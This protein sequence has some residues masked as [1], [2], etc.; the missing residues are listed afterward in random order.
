MTGPIQQSTSVNESVLSIGVT[1]A[2]VQGPPFSRILDSAMGANASTSTPSGLQ[3][4]IGLLM[5]GDAMRSVSGESASMVRARLTSAKPSL[6]AL[7]AEDL[8]MLADVL[9]ETGAG[10]AAVG[11]KGR[12]T[13]DPTFPSNNYGITVAE[14][15]ERLSPDALKALR[16]I[17]QD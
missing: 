14:L 5:G 4:L 11:G 16:S 10:G 15:R 3:A 9:G 6:D 8:S 1:E 12:R 7:S 13:P 2:P 17:V